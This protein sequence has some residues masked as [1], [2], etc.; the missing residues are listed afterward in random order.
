MLGMYNGYNTNFNS[1]EFTLTPIFNIKI[2]IKDII[3]F[4]RETLSDTE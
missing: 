1:I 3:Y 2:G 4:L